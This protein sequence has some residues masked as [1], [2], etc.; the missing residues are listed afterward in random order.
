MTDI[1]NELGLGAW[2]CGDGFCQ[3]DPTAA[4]LLG[5]PAQRFVG[6]LE[7]LLSS[8]SGDERVR[9]AETLRTAQ[10]GNTADIECRREDGEA[11]LLLRAQCPAPGRLQGFVIDITV[12]RLRDQ[13]QQQARRLEALS[14]LAG[15]LAQEFHSLLTVVTGSCEVARELLPIGH[16]VL[17]AIGQIQDAGRRAITLAS[18]LL[19]FDRRHQGT[20]SPVDLDLRI[21][22]LEGGL[23]E[24][25][26]P[27]V[28]LRFDLH[29]SPA[30]GLVDGSLFDQV[31][32]HLVRNA[33]DAMP[34]GGRLQ[35]TSTANDQAIII[36]VADTGMGIPPDLADRIFEPFFSTKHDG[37]AVGLGL[38][39]A[40]NLI[41]RWGG[42][43][44]LDSRSSQGSTFTITLPIHARSERLPGGPTTT[45]T[46]RRMR[47]SILLAEDDPGVRELLASFLR[48]Q[49]YQV[50]EAEDGEVAAQIAAH[51]AFDLVLSDVVLPKRAGPALADLLRRQ[52]PDQRIILMSGFTD[53]PE[54][55]ERIGQAGFRFL[56]K[57]FTPQVLAKAIEELLK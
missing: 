49:G 14:R 51:Q 19:A 47:H 53:S 15:G 5:L 50:T 54:L 6:D 43:I 21:L 25:L 27:G 13:R 39:A 9:V 26:G 22:A 31:I 34:H 20:E 45:A 11:W 7:H 46:M 12:I 10:A 35:V 56:Q 44:V 2:S 28:D 23:R 24:D 36:S 57:P 8:L 29:A 38:A 16:P 42:R 41:H 1:P 37:Q 40:Q 52:R 17:D 3:T 4:R 18:Q 33:N 32:T 30:L 48:H 55:T